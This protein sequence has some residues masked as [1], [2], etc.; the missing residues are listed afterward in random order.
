VHP[1]VDAAPTVVAAC[2]NRE[3]PSGYVL[4]FVSFGRQGMERDMDDKWILETANRVKGELEKKKIKDEKF[5]ET[6]KLKR[7]LGPGIWEELKD[8]LKGS[9]ERLNAELGIEIAKFNRVNGEEVIVSGKADGMDTTMTVIFNPSKSTVEYHSQ[10]GDSSK[11]FEITINSDGHA[12]FG[13]HGMPYCLAAAD[14]GKEI[15]KHV[16]KL[17]P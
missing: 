17:Y 4:F 13:A 7:D 9:C 14:A 12:G 1:L 10:S 15:M 6:Q 8:W 2:R 16:L 5:L 11:T 3:I